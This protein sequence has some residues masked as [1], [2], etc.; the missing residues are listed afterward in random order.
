MKQTFEN[1]RSRVASIKLWKTEHE[2]FVTAIVGAI[3]FGVGTI[4][5]HFFMGRKTDGGNTK[6]N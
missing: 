5:G 1:I 3:M 4:Y 2:N 6:E